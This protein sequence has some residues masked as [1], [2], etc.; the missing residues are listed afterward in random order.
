MDADQKWLYV[1][2]AQQ[3]GPVTTTVLRRMLKRGILGISAATLAWSGGDSWKQLGAIRDFENEARISLAMWYIIDNERL[4]QGPISSA[5]VF[6]RIQ[7]GSINATTLVC[8]QAFTDNKWISVDKVPILASELPHHGQ[9]HPEQSQLEVAFD[10]PTESGAQHKSI[11]SSDPVKPNHCSTHGQKS[12]KHKQDKNTWV[13]I[14]GLPA[15]VTEAELVAHMQKA[16]LLALDADSQRPRIKLY[17]DDQGRLKGDA[18]ICYHQ[19]ASVQL[20][21]TVLD[22]GYL[23]P[24]GKPLHITAAATTH[25]TSSEPSSSMGTNVSA[26]LPTTS[27]AK[28]RARDDAHIELTTGPASKRSR[29]SAPAVSHAK[30]RTALQAVHA[31]LSWAD[32]DDRTSSSHLKIVILE[33]MFRP[34]DLVPSD[35]ELR[36]A[37]LR[38]EEARSTFEIELEEDVAS[39]CEKLGEVEKITLFSKHPRG[40]IAVKFRV[41]AAAHAAVRLLDGRAFGGRIVRAYFYDGETDYTAATFQGETGTLDEGE[42]HK[43]HDAF[44]AWL[45]QSGELPPE[46]RLRVEDD[47]ASS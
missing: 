7:D 33:N 11:T 45:E 15:D 34:S 2:D 41:S 25:A 29:A 21:L 9:P 46:L 17:R 38:D 13:Y 39:E 3:K 5:N 36:E 47:S 28:V 6:C 23:R 22:G 8:S 14:E 44:G 26:H 40:V 37:A 12:I 30:V 31:Q 16:G 18:S 19:P 4:T 35:E 1:T 24:G 43:R 20:A 10:A 27:H 42:E 32:D